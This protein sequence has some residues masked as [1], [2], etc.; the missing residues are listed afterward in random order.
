MLLRWISVLLLLAFSD[1]PVRAIQRP[2][3]KT[4][5]R[6]L[7]KMP[8]VE[9]RVSLDF[10]ADQGFLAFRTA[11]DPA[12]AV[13]DIRDKL[14]ASPNDTRLLLEVA[15]NRIDSGDTPAGRRDL[16]RAADA[17]HK[18][19]DAEPG[20][21]RL[22]LDLAS[23][24]H[25]LSRQAEADSLLRE[26]V[27][28]APRSQ[29][30]WLALSTFLEARAWEI[31]ANI[32]DWKGRRPYAELCRAVLRGEPSTETA[33]R[34]AS[35]MDESLSAAREAV[36]LAE[37][38]A[39]AQHRLAL[40]L[41]AKD[42]F[43]S[44]R[45]KISGL[46]YASPLAETLIF[47]ATAQP[48]LDKAAELEPENPIRLATALLWRA[49][50][51]ATDKRIA[52]NEL[53]RRAIWDS[54]SD[55][56]RAKIESGFERLDN[57][58]DTSDAGAAWQAL[59]T[60]RFALR[61]DTH[62]AAE[63]LR[64]AASALPD[65]EQAWETL[66]TALLRAQDYHELAAVCEARVMV[67]PTTRNRVLLAKAHEKLGHISRAEEE[68]AAALAV[69]QNDFTANLS[70]ANLLMRESTDDD[71]S[72]RVRQ[73]LIAAERAIRAN[74]TGDQLISLALAQSIYHGLTDEI[75]IA[76]Q[77]LKAALAYAKD[78][79]DVNAALNAIGY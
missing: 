44:L 20:N 31:A 27:K 53:N 70:L 28:V 63:A 34:A 4:T 9:L 3:P 32:S 46:D 58:S 50:S 52:V 69:N 67:R 1:I 35:Y 45:R 49:L 36:R 75:D 55:S 60:L 11:K 62:G 21:A 41:A 19:L 68:I 26:A 47:S 33:D 42:C 14:N 57:F 23:A 64:Y 12:L 29:T 65:S 5:L 38:S 51:E 7:A 25:G 39:P 6:A 59:G 66:S 18:R 61:N 72:P 8:R 16:Q 43:Q 40:A 78:H 79:P 30:N 77:I 24:L 73:S 71:I 10:T 2:D 76:R 15:A 74:P 22:R 54:L 56:T 37:E 48:A 17:L 13:T